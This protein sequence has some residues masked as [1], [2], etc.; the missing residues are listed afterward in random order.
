MLLSFATT[1]NRTLSA[2]NK[3][4]GEERSKVMISL[5]LTL[6]PLI[7]P[8][9]GVETSTPSQ[10]THWGHK[11]NGFLVGLQKRLNGEEI[12]KRGRKSPKRDGKWK[13]QSHSA[14]SDCRE[15]LQLLPFGSPD[16][17]HHPVLKI[18]PS[19][20][21][22]GKQSP[23]LPSGVLWIYPSLNPRCCSCRPRVY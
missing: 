19:P 7:S 5:P 15:S 11:M 18:A 16:L 23:T 21:G 13:W 9:L 17:S 10:S 22:E 8:S 6:T 3:G 2:L 4:R 12:G 1:L 20:I 14:S